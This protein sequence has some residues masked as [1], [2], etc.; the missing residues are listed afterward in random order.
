MGAA[1]VW[2]SV[3]TVGCYS[4]AS[5]HLLSAP[6]VILMMPWLLSRSWACI[7]TYGWAGGKT[8]MRS[9]RSMT[10]GHSL[11]MGEPRAEACSLTWAAGSS[12]SGMAVTHAQTCECHTL[13][14]HGS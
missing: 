14:I 1:A 11:K 6:D 10:G 4:F 9:G 5:T 13:P 7:S 2:Q 3:A 12:G 8:Y